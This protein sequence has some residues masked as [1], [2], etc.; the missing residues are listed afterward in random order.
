MI[1]AAPPLTGPAADHR[2]D[3]P[4]TLDDTVAAGLRVLIL[5]ENESVPGD[6]RVWDISLTLAAAGAEVVVICPQDELG[7]EAHYERRDGVEIHRYRPR[8]AQSGP[9]GYLREYGHAFWST[10]KL[11]R[12]LSRTRRFDI[13]HACNPPDFLLFAALPARR[14]GARFVFDHHDLTP[15]L[16]QTRFG[17]RY[18]SLHRATLALE[19]SCFRTADVVIATNESYREVACSRGGRSAEDVFVVRNAPDLDRLVPVAPEPALKRGRP[20]LIAYLGVMA[21]QDG[22]DNALRALAVLR[23][24]RQDWHAVFGGEGSAVPALRQLAG[25]LGLG[26]MVEFAG[27]LN[28]TEICRLLSTADVCLSPEPRTPLNDRSTMVKVAEYMAMSRPVVAFALPET[29]KTAG[30]AAVYA[31]SGD[32]A[33][34]AQRIDDLLDDPQRR[35]QMGAIGRTR[36]ERSMSWAKS[37]AVLLTAYHRALTRRVSSR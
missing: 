28:D 16:F 1:G 30:E 26:D 8:F 20:L 37:S 4:L 33:G 24:R 11:V 31:A 5:N 13:V 25:D 36:V 22:V 21:P 10:W 17:D 23:E 29:E 32:I 27:W 15:E 14:R 3:A 9:S 7:G 2:D 6:R 35:G 19:R 12:Q 18:R 34:F